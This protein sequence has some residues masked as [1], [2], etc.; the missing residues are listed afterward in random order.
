MSEQ[1][2]LIHPIHPYEVSR[3]RYLEDL[4]TVAPLEPKYV[5][6]C[7]DKC[8][9]CNRKTFF[10]KKKK[11]IY[12]WDIR[13]TNC[14]HHHVFHKRCLRHEK[15][16]YIYQQQALCI[17]FEDGTRIIPDAP[18]KFKLDGEWRFIDDE[19]K[20]VKTEN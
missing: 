11:K 19:W 20:I 9:F 17:G 10:L 6:M 18:P 8:F 13:T 4:K 12:G 2:S 3:N 14:T 15:S 1:R 7:F 16:K 5:F